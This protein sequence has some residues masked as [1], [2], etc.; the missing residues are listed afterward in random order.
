MDGCLLYYNLH[1]KL[2]GFRCHRCRGQS[3][4]THR[5]IAFVFFF[6]LNAMQTESGVKANIEQKINKYLIVTTTMVLM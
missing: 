4:I 1:S 6:L 5:L 2:N 3:E